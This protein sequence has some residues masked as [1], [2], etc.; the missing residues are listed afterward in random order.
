MLD[1]VSLKKTYV[2]MLLQA[3]LQQSENFWFVI[4]ILV[5]AIILLCFWIYLPASMAMKR[6]RSALG[7]V[8]L[9]WLISPLWAIVLLLILGDTTEKVLK[10]MNRDH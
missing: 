7:W 5:I 1:K 9:A 2:I 8:L 3:S 6:G 4:A 10:K